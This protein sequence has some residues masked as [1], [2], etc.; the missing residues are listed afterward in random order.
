MLLH[1][2][3]LYMSVSGGYK[4]MYL[5]CEKL[6]VTVDVQRDD[7]DNGKCDFVWLHVVQ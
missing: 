3:S 6:C 4:F 2:T 5:E 7:G 1:V